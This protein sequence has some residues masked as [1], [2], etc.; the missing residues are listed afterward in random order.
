MKGWRTAYSNR[1]AARRGFIDAVKTKDSSGFR[2]GK[3]MNEVVRGLRQLEFELNGGWT[4]VATTLLIKAIGYIAIGA[5]VHLGWS[6][7]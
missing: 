2:K 5:L 3:R 6:L 4:A 1:D 7:V